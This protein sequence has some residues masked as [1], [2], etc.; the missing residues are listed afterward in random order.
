MLERQ[1]LQQMVPGKLDSH[2]YKN[3]IIPFLNSKHKLK[4]TT[5]PYMWSVIA[6]FLFCNYLLACPIFYCKTVT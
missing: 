6:F 5:V 4:K 3:E 2:M 1:S